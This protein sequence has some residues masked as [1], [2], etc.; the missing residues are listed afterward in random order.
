M[1]RF[2]KIELM[3]FLSFHALFAI[4]GAEIAIYNGEG[5]WYDGIVSFEQ[6][7]D[8]K[9]ITHER[10]GP[11]DINL[12]NLTNYYNG[13]Y[14]PGG[15]A[16]Y[17]KRAINETGL[18]HIRE[19]VQGGGA[20]IGMCAGAYFA[21]DSVEWEGGIYDY[22]LD[23]FQGTATGAIDEI[24]PWPEYVM[25]VIDLNPGNPINQYE[26]PSQTTLYYGGPVF[27]P[28]QNASIDT[29]ATWREHAND[30][31]IINFSYGSGRVLL[32][33]PHP[34]IEEDGDRDSTD[35]AQE[36]DDNGTE[37]NLLWT[38]MDWVLGRPISKP[39]GVG[40][41]G[42]VNDDGSANSTDALIILSC[43]V[44]IDVSQFCPMNCGD[45]N[46]DGSVNSTDALIIL[47]ADV[48]I[49]TPYSVGS[50]GCP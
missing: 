33:G 48:G 31:A 2:Y 38:A 5:T 6:F 4:E 1:A 9:G 22:Q 11:L 20:Y 7:L 13:I 14:F 17:Y 18:Q 37:W 28:Q 35:F 30:A 40:I 44:G 15:D 39:P 8:W 27:K 49:S 47:S 19:L 46:E 32:V 43:D 26:P 21:S 29:V 24:A 41:L 36:L 25:T 12:N 10:L 34:E 42:D 45:V 23:L 16:Y 50:N 3:L